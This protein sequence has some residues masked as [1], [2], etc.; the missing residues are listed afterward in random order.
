[1][2]DERPV[3]SVK[4]E[5][6]VDKAGNAFIDVDLALVDFYNIFGPGDVTFHGK[7]HKF[8]PFS[9]RWDSFSFCFLSFYSGSGVD[10]SSK[11]VFFSLCLS[12]SSFI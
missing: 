6:F 9:F 1:M 10:S 2:F 4:G 11:I 3:R 8:L 12:R 7:V 5:L